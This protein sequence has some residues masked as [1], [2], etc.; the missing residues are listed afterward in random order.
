MGGLNY[1]SHR[2][3]LVSALKTLSSIL[4][5]FNLIIFKFLG[6]HFLFLSL[7]VTFRGN[8][9]EIQSEE[10]VKGTRWSGYAGLMRKF[11]TRGFPFGPHTCK[12]ANTRILTI[13]PNWKVFTETP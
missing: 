9:L 4:F 12:L 7:K 2:L 1:G 6:G 13:T 11:S 3:S 8:D 5:V 10:N